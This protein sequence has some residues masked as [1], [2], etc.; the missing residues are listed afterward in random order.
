MS[1]TGEWIKEMWYIYTM[2]YYSAIQ[3]NEMMPFGATW[4]DPE[5]IILCEVSQRKINII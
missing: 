5:M 1:S 2:D 3:K 4:M